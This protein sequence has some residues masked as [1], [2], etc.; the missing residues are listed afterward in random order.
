MKKKQQEKEKIP[1]NESYTFSP[2]IST[3]RGAYWLLGI[4][5]FSIMLLFTILISVN[6]FENVFDGIPF[7]VSGSL[8]GFSVWYWFRHFRTVHVDQNGIALSNLFSYQL[9]NWEDIRRL[10][11]HKEHVFEFSPVLYTGHN[12]GS[13]KKF[14]TDLIELHLKSGRKRSIVADF[15]RDR[16]GLREVLKSFRTLIN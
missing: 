13:Y 6:A 11:I 2:S 10:Q 7:L 1:L 4:I 12:W 8:W 14:R 5:V 15:H 9:Y 16:E 3:N